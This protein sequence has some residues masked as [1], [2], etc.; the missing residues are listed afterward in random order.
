MVDFSMF[1]FSLLE[2]EFEL[3]KYN[4]FKALEEC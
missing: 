4:F 3:F 1:Y 2:Y